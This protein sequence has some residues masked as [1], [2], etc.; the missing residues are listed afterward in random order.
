MN[1]L[2]EIMRPFYEHMLDLTMKDPKRKCF[3]LEVLRQTQKVKQFLMNCY[4]F[5]GKQYPT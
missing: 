2:E 1:Q 3:L 5:Q 4:L